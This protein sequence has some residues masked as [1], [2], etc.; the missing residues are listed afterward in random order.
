MK[1]PSL[2]LPAMNLREKI[3]I[4]LGCYIA[5]ILVM[6]YIAQKDL[7]TASE[8]LETLELAYRLSYNFV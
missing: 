6:S 1:F 8:K 3:L 4:A 5:G 7:V 2:T